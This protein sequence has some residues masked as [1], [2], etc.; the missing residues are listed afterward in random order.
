MISRRRRF[1]V[2]ALV[3]ALTLTACDAR[4]EA[5]PAEMRPDTP[6]MGAMPGMEGMQMDP[7]MM[8][9]HADELDQ[10]ASRMRQHIQQ[11]RELSPEQW[12]ERM[13]EHVAQVSQMLTLM[14]RQVGEMDMGMGMSDEQMGAMMGMSAE[15][16]R[17]MM[18]QMRTLR[19]EVEQLQTASQAEVRARMPAHLERLEEMLRMVEQSAAHMRQS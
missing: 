7:A 6:V 2:F 5:R 14:N 9:R 12:H 8:R 10:T 18:E 19:A 16:H 11:M 15:E 3:S 13:G 1:L 4:E 17:Q